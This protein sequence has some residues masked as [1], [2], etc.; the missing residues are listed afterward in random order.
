MLWRVHLNTSCDLTTAWYCSF[1]CLKYLLEL[2]KNQA[3]LRDEGQPGSSRYQ[4]AVWPAGCWTLCVCVCC[5][6]I[7]ECVFTQQSTWY[8][9]SSVCCKT[10][11]RLNR[12]SLMLGTADLMLLFWL[13]SAKENFSI[14]HETSQIIFWLCFEMVSHLLSSKAWNRWGLVAELN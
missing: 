3:E 6:W 14:R 5:R 9:N 13:L 8:N 2:F 12:C 4:Q 11:R 10:P 1:S 7:C